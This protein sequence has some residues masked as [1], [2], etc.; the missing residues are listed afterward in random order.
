M[1]VLVP[2]EILQAAREPGEGGA[3]MVSWRSPVTGEID[4]DHL[5]ILGE[6]RQKAAP[7]MATASQAVHE[8]EGLSFTL[9]S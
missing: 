4:G 5:A 1:E 6:R 7:G 2:E 9:K 3:V 8:E